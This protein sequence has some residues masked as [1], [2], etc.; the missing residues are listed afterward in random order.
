MRD[1][2]KIKALATFVVITMLIGTQSFAASTTE[3][4]TA[5]GSAIANIPLTVEDTSGGNTEPVVVFSAYV[6]SELPVKI[7]LDGRVIVPSNAKI[8][9][10]VETKGIK[11]SDINVVIADGWSAEDWDADFSSK[12]TDTKDV[13]LKFR[14]DKLSAD[15]SFNITE[16]DWLIPKNSYIDLNM[17]AKVPK[18]TG[19]GSKGNIATVQFTLDWSGDDTTTG[20]STSLTGSYTMT[21]TSGE[22]GTVNDMSPVSTTSSG[23]ITSLPDV[24]PDR[25]YALMKWVDADTGFKVQVGDTLDG[26][27]TIKPIFTYVGV[28][29]VSVNFTTT[30]CTID[31]GSQIEVASGKTFGEISKPTATP[32]D[33]S[34]TFDGYYVNDVKIDDSYVINSAITIEIRYT[35]A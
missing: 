20:P 13:S 25:G 22:H 21:V 33:D 12:A 16:D 7:D 15:G 24:T 8:I 23:V 17:G 10:G 29:N 5:G 4:T 30:N 32:T 9:N 19:L 18:Q 35:T 6:P 34:Y 11:V 31:S 27:I 3:V 28:R 14:G 2:K 1:N 26:D